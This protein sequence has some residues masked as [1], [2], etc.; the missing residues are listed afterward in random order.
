MPTLTLTVDTY[1]CSRVKLFKLYTIIHIF[2]KIRPGH[3]IRF[4]QVAQR[5]YFKKCKRKSY[6]FLIHY[7]LQ[8]KLLI[9]YNSTFFISSETHI[10]KRITTDT[11]SP[12]SHISF[13]V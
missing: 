3:K 12:S 6:S 7:S 9:Y 13:T 4:F 1:F 10:V 8:W 11:N 5:L 2:S